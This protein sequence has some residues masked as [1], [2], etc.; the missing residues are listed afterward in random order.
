[1][2][3]ASISFENYRNLNGVK[4]N[5][6]YDC[7]FLVGENSIGKTNALDCILTII[8]GKNFA[9]TDYY[10]P[11]LPIVIKMELVYKQSPANRKPV[12]ETVLVKQYPDDCLKVEEQASCHLLEKIKA[13]YIKEKMRI[14]EEQVEKC[15]GKNKV[16]EFLR[17][18]NDLDIVKR[19]YGLYSRPIQNF[20]SGS[21]VGSNY[22]FYILEIILKI[23][24]A[25]CENKEDNGEILLLLDQP[26]NGLH[27]FAQKTL[28][29]DLLRLASG[30]DKG[31]NRLIER[32]YGVKGFCAQLFFV[33]HSDR[34]LGSDYSKIIRFYRQDG[35]V[36][37]VS[38]IE[39]S[40]QISKSVAVEKQMSMQFPYFSLAIFAKCV[41]LIEG[42][43]EFGAME[44][45][46][47]S[48]G[49]DLDFLGISVISANGEGNIPTLTKILNAFKIKVFSVRDRD[50]Y[51]R[52]ISGDFITDRIDFE[53]EVVGSATTES[54]LKILQSA[55]IDYLNAE[56]P[57]ATLAKRNN[58]YSVTNKRITKSIRFKD[59]K[60]SEWERRL[61]F[62]SLLY[63]NKS[64]LTGASVGKVLPIEQI[65]PVYAK[66]LLCAK[67]HVEKG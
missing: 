6:D 16:I 48:L 46:A 14:T 35:L 25:V 10:N 7:N 18:F 47:Q 11:L 9:D 3:I 49:I 19:S 61:F 15:I 65:P 21:G 38:G 67:E 27:P 24:Q 31:F 53:D 55:G 22:S 43:S 5:F 60:R 40:R 58:R 26:E 59:C 62:L 39:V 66:V 51:S 13:V 44:H 29:K 8:E 37:A 1:M 17:Y 42:A 64:V 45:F 12:R 50:S 20:F 32:F 56:V 41:V 54:I 23:M 63:S 36:R 4:L 34:I 52:E 57:V 33:S 30:E 2:R 28:V